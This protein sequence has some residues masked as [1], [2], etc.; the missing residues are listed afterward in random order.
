M[1]M[2]ICIAMLTSSFFMHTQRARE[3]GR[4]GGRGD[5]GIEVSREG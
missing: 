4:E 2:Y 1:Y 5:P 3:G